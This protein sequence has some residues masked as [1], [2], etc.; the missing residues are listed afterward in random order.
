MLKTRLLQTS[1]KCMQADFSMARGR[2]SSVTGRFIAAII[3]PL[4]AFLMRPISILS[5]IDVQAWHH[6]F[7]KFLVNLVTIYCY[8]CSRPNRWQ[9]SCYRRNKWVY[10][11]NYFLYNVAYHYHLSW[12]FHRLIPYFGRHLKSP[13][14]RTCSEHEAAK[15][16]IYPRVLLA[17]NSFPFQLSAH[18]LV[19]LHTC[20]AHRSVSRI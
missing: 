1:S 6:D 4:D 13:V 12:S 8:H 14:I 3:W 19:G 5:E 20:I 10:L 9:C 15:M 2:L 17:E 18:V 16:S 7:Y 11:F